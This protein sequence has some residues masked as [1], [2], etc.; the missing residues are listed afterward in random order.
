MH[1]NVIASILVNFL[2]FETPCV[3]LPTKSSSAIVNLVN[4]LVE[5]VVMSG[6]SETLYETG[7]LAQ[8]LEI[9][10]EGVVM[11]GESETLYETGQL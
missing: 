3:S 9:K 5:G 8:L 4:L 11:S 2:P 1:S 10:L 7:Q 6:E